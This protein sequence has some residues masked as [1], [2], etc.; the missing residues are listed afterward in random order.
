MIMPDIEMGAMQAERRVTVFTVF[1][2]NPRLMTIALT[3]Q[4]MN[5]DDIISLTFTA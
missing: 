3:T 1:I 4:K 5:H 2:S